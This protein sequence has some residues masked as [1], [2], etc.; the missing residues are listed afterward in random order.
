MIFAIF[1][2]LFFAF[3]FTI[4]GGNGWRFFRN[5]NKVKNR[6][7]VL[8]FVL[9]G[10]FVSTLLVFI[11]AFIFT[12][13]KVV[14]SSGQ[15]PAVYDPDWLLSGLI[16]LMWLVAILPSL[17]EEYQALAGTGL[18]IKSFWNTGKGIVRFDKYYGHKKLIQRGVL[19]GA[20]MTLATGY[21]PFICFSLLYLPISWVCLIYGRKY[22]RSIQNFLKLEN[23]HKLSPIDYIGWFAAE[24]FT[25]A[26]V[27]GLPMFLWLSA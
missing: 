15:F 1:T 3:C 2:I 24:L 16:A 22:G 6:N 18:Y 23:K 27:F 10:R 14:Y 17:G 11:Y 4:K 20:A 9:G 26:F 19:M 13:E 7:K 8:D 5:W 21:I 25:G 12:A